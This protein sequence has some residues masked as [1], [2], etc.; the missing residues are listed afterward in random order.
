MVEHERSEYGMDALDDEDA[1]AVLDEIEGRVGINL[2]AETKSK[3]K[4]KWLPEGMDPTLEEL[5]KW[6]LLVEVLQEI[7]EVMVQLQATSRRKYLF[8][9]F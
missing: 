8:Y 9:L 5:P 7:E 4:K 2:E 6:S 1:W 3:K